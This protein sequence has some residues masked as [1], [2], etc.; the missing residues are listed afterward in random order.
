MPAQLCLSALFEQH[1][2]A[3]RR[4]VHSRYGQLCPGRVEDAVSDAFLVLCS[5]PDLARKAWE[6]GGER[7]V[8]SL[9]RVIAWR[10]ARA[11]VCRGAGAFERG[12][13]DDVEPQGVGPGSLEARAELALHLERAVYI[14]AEQISGVH[15]ERLALALTERLLSDE[16]DTEIARRHQ[17]PREYVNRARHGLARMFSDDAG[18]RALREG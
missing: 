16:S 9:L 8:L 13:G 5:Q 3:I 7:Q 4:Y 2:P 11:G 18:G 14:V 15:A 10:C 1:A 12:L 17:I 6:Q